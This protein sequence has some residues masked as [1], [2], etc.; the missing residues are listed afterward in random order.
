M[1]LNKVFLVGRVTADPQ[2]RSTPGGQSVAT[3]GVATNRTWTDKNNQ[4][5]EE[6]EFHNVVLWG[7]QA[8]IAGQYL[9]K[10]AM[11][12]IEGRLQTRSWTDKTGGQRKTTEIVADRLQ[13]GPRPQ[14]G[15]GQ[16]G[17][18]RS[19]SGSGAAGSSGSSGSS[20]GSRG[21]AAP[22]GVSS[23]DDA[24]AVEEVPVIS[25]DDEEEIKPEEIPF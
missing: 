15:G 5:Q 9:T 13:L 4:R 22:S 2:V 3:I 12:L 23:K 6:T 14:G 7:R 17:G 1:D 18:F 25:L 21:A 8:E 20:A 11:V 24:P 10:G 16:G 19:Q